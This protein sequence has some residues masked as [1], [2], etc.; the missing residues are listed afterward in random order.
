[1]TSPLFLVVDMVDLRR[2]TSPIAAA[3]KDRLI[4][5]DNIINSPSEY[6]NQVAVIDEE[7]RHPL[8][9]IVMGIDEN[10]DP[11]FTRGTNGAPTLDNRI[12]E[13][14]LTAFVLTGAGG[15][16]DEQ[17]VSPATL[18]ALATDIVEIMAMDINHNDAAARHLDIRL[19]DGTN[20]SYL[21]REASYNTPNASLNNP[22]Y[23]FF[24]D[25]GGTAF[26]YAFTNHRVSAT[27]YMVVEM[28]NLADTKVANL[29]VAW[30]KVG[31][32]L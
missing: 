15:V 5:I 7:I 31:S 17:I 32:T 23:P 13:V 14:S 27:T 6:R 9:V 26:Q 8:P 22:I 12:T 4:K 20:V 16:G 2:F 29:K 1:M 30:R 28:D 19:A 3:L 25:N 11:V 18:G 24:V 21:I 10:G